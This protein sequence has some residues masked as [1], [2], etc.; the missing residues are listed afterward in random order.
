MGPITRRNFLL[1]VAAL[2]VASR[3]LAQSKPA[4]AARKLSQMTLTVADLKRSIDF[5]QGLFGMP[6]Q[7]RR[8]GAVFLRVGTGPQYLALI[9]GGASAK[10]G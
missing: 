1:S 7:A 8:E 5:Y 2:P 9:D 4:L 3:A 10:P 6:I